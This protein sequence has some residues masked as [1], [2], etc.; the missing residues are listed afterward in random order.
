MEA[1]NNL[2]GR[3]QETSLRGQPPDQCCTRCGQTLPHDTPQCPT[4]KA[5]S[6]KFH[7][8]GHYKSC[9]KTRVSI[10]EVSLNSDDEVFLGVVLEETAGAKNTE[11]DEN[12]VQQ[13][14]PGV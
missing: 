14:N 12:T 1:K 4:K 8:K 9:C 10:K 6:H 11:V 2:E 13:P 5:V 3:S 7:K